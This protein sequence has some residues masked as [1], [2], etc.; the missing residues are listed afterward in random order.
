MRFSLRTLFV[1]VTIVSAW[2]AHSHRWARPRQELRRQGPTCGI[3]FIENEPNWPPR[4][5][6]RWLWMLNEN[7]VQAV[8]ISYRC[9]DD[10]RQR[11]KQLF[12]EAAMLILDR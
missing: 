2:L 10:N 11:A 8:H 4:R 7:G 5:A 3:Y 6:P 12:P 9:S 1:V